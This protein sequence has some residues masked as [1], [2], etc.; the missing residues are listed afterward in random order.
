MEPLFLPKHTYM[1][2]ERRWRLSEVLDYER[3]LA[4]LPPHGPLDPVEERWLSAAQMRE[5]FGRVSDMWI[6]RRTH[7]PPV[8]R[9]GGRPR[10]VHPNKEV[11]VK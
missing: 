8:E 3:A 4:G 5:R 11:S 9:R 10:K 7:R 2:R 1:G 6:W